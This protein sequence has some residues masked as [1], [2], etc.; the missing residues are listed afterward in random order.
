V[1]LNAKK[2]KV[3]LI[4]FGRKTGNGISHMGDNTTGEGDGDDEKIRIDFNS[5]SKSTKELFVTVNI[6]SNG[7][8]FKDVSNAYVRLCASAKPY[9]FE[10]GPEMARYPLVSNI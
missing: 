3:D 7:K 8:T 1:C 5:V 10:V 2:E 6:Y 4:Y 9:T